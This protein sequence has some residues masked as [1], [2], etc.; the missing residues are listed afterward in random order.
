MPHLHFIVNPVAGGKRCLY[1]F[2]QAAAFLNRCGADYSI[3]YSE[4]PGHA[5]ELA[6]QALAAG[7]DQVV[8]VGGDGTVREVAQELAH[9]GVP[10]GIL[11]FGTGNDLTRVLSIPREPEAAAQLL[12]EGPVCLVDA[13]MANDRLYLNVAGFGFDVDVLLKTRLYKDKVHGRAA[14]LLGVLH[15]LCGLDAYPCKIHA[16][17]E[18]LE[19]TVLMVAVGNGTHI[20]GGMMVTP[21]A[22][23]SDGLLDVCVVKKVGWL[24]VLHCLSRFIRGTHIHL[25]IVRYFQADSVA[26]ECAAGTPVQLD[27]EVI[28]STP[29]RFRVLPAALAV[30]CRNGKEDTT[31]L[32]WN[33]KT[34]AP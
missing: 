20:G 16:N 21:G 17:G 10:L 1:Q 25:D 6:R 8:A 30:I 22:C 19:E 28:G 26:I 29:V 15:A 12:L 3:V 5:S 24:R 14:Y 33:Q 18:S 34:A 4:Y 23:V 13:A 32:K 27:G 31:T 9:T 11:P 2:R 7:W